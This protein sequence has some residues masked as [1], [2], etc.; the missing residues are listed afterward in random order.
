MNILVFYKAKKGF[1]NIL[2]LRIKPNA[3]PFSEVIALQGTI[4][5]YTQSCIYL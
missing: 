4:L 3:S 2:E 1:T 5:Y